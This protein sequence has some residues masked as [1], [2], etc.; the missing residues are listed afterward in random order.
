MP[1]P[2][3]ECMKQIKLGHYN[4]NGKELWPGLQGDD[5][6]NIFYH[7][8]DIDGLCG[9]LLTKIMVGN[10]THRPHG[11]YSHGWEFRNKDSSYVHFGGCQIAFKNP[12]LVMSMNASA[13]FDQVP[14]GII[15]RTWRTRPKYGAAGREWVH[16]ADS[17]R[18]IAA[19]VTTKTAA[20]FIG[21][22]R[23]KMM[24]DMTK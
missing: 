18:I 24:Q 4:M 5:K 14:P 20:L 11:I 2:S 10:P 3:Q 19:R 23:V 16:S 13:L 6:P 8:T 17:I 21:K 15:L 9:I 7:G 1:R 12:G 22:H